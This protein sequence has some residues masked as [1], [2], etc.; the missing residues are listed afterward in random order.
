MPL[1]EKVTVITGGTGGLGRTVSNVFARTGSDVIIAGQEQP[2]SLLGADPE[3]SFIDTDVTNEESVREMV[4]TVYQR[5]GRIDILLCLVGGFAGGTSVADTP[6]DDFER[7]VNLNLRS[8]FLCAKYVFPL[9][10]AKQWGRIVT[11]GARPVVHP[12]SGIGA[13][14]ASKAG[15]VNLT[16]VLALEGNP[17]GITANSVLP[18]VIDTPG[19][20]KAM[21]DADFSR[22]VTPQRIAETLIFLCSESGAD[23]SGAAIPV[24]GKS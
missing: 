20:R 10:R 9:M 18:S 15:V 17:Y 12:V 13:Y 5:H 16:Q 4:D 19:N 22:W 24:Y 8:V 2:A 7:M 23:V 21:P 11:V 14:S 3:V 6:V 1:R